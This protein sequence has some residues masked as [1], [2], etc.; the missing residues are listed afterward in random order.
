VSAAGTL[1]LQGAEAI[2]DGSLTLSAGST[3]RYNGTAASYTLKNYAYKNLIIDGGAATVFSFPANLT[4]INTLTLNNSITSLAGFNLIATTLVNNATLRLQGNETVTI[5]T[6]YTD[7]GLVEYVGDGAGGLNS[8]TIKDFGATDYYNL[9][10]AGVAGSETF[11]VSS[12]LKLNGALTHSTGTLNLGANVTTAGGTITS[13]DVVTLGTN[14][15]VDTTDAGGSPAGA[16]MTFTSTINGAQALTLTAGAGDVLLSGTIGGTTR[17]S[18]LTAS[19][20]TVNVQTV[21]TTGAQ[22]YTGATTLN[23]SLNSNTAGAITVS[24][25]PLTIVP[26]PPVKV[27]ASSEAV[28]VFGVPPLIRMQSKHGPV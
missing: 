7:S 1:Q 11:T 10:I 9:R 4:S 5:T 21:S 2:T 14:T 22:S 27:M 20:N 17:L 26:A 8:F 3:V 15:I 13:T 24:P 25:A 6:M 28:N 19:G 16:N 12:A 23:G 18:S